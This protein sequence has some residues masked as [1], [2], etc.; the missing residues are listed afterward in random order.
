MLSK[1]Q[2]A[3]VDAFKNLGLKVT[4]HTEQS[5]SI[6]TPIEGKDCIVT[7]TIGIIN[8]RDADNRIDV[9]ID[10]ENNKVK[11]VGVMIVGDES[12]NSEMALY[13]TDT[14]NKPL[15]PNPFW[16]VKILKNWCY[17]RGINLY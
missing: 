14:V 1:I 6:N 2:Q 11:R 8:L 12:T 5:I 16:M 17:S 9:A 4:K 3:V 15:G 10:L 7:N 13:T